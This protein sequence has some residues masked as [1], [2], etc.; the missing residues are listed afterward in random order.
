MRPSKLQWIRVDKPVA[1]EILKDF[2]QGDA[3][4]VF[5]RDLERGPQGKLWLISQAG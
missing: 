1:N 3:D 5:G 2:S 4:V